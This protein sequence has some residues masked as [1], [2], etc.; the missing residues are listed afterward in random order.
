MINHRRSTGVFISADAIANA[1]E[2]VQ[3][4]LETAGT[5]P[6]PLAMVLER[7]GALTSED[8]LAICS[9]AEIRKLLEHIRDDYL[10]CQV[11]F[12]AGC[13]YVDPMSAEHKPRVLHFDDF[14]GRTDVRHSGQLERSL[15]AIEA[16][17]HRIRRDERVRLHDRDEHGAI[18]VHPATQHS[19]YT[20]WC[21]TV[22][23]PQPRFPLPDSERC[24]P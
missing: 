7:D 20:V 16:A 23:A 19:I 11:L 5:R 18:H 14:H 3:E 1:P 2:A 10:A 8:G 12:A 9:P 13:E 6:E 17:L 21:E 24:N 15:D 22:A 4:W